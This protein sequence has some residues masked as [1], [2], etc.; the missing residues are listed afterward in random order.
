MGINLTEKE[1]KLILPDNQPIKFIPVIISTGNISNSF[2][3]KSWEKADF[4]VFI[5][6]PPY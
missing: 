6:I 1:V 4:T 2:F 5:F 3:F